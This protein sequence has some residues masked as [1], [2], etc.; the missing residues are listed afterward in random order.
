MR[1]LYVFEPGR[2]ICRI[3]LRICLHLLSGTNDLGDAADND[4]AKELIQSLLD[5][6]HD[7]GLTIY[8]CEED[9]DWSQQQKC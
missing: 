3:E 5:L 6:F 4:L 9:L 8:Q 7:G 2:S 1:E